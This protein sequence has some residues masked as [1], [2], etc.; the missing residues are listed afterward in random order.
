M[1]R[2]PR[3]LILQEWYKYSYLPVSFQIVL[4]KQINIKFYVFLLQGPD[5]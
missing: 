2:V 5:L 1:K 3:D 4:Q